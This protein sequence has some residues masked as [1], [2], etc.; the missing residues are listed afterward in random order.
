MQ[1]T[2]NP[3][4]PGADKRR[5]LDEPHNVRKIYLGL[6]AVCVALGAGDF[7][8]EK[9]AHFSAEDYFGFFGFFG[10]VSYV[11]IVMSAKQLR[12]ILMRDEDYYDR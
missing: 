2:E 8:Y 11:F 3:K 10:F 4:K 5:W 7:L 6:L 1:D 9:H 12:K